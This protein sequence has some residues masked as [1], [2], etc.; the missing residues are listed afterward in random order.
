VT[1][2]QVIEVDWL[3]VPEGSSVDLDRVLLVGDGENVTV[4]TPTVEGTRV[5]ATSRG[6][7]R[8]RKITV[9]RYKSKVRYRRKTG[10]RQPYTRLVIDSIVGPGN[11]SDRQEDSE[12]GT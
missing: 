1:P 11:G 7:G 12:S 10:H 8:A 6:D 2:G 4:G 5:V 9:L 3:D